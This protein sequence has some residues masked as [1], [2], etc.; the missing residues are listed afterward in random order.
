MKLYK[1]TETYIKEAITCVKEK[2]YK[3]AFEYTN[4]GLEINNNHYM[5]KRLKQI[6]HRDSEKIT[7]NFPNVTYLPSYP[8]EKSLQNIIS[9]SDYLHPKK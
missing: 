7:E 8:K 3:E 4:K 2:K 9:L 6:I 5:L 1:L